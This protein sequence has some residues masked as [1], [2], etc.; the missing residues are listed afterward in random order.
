V[1]QYRDLYERSTVRDS[2][3][4]TVAFGEKAERTPSV[5]FVSSDGGDGFG[6]ET[7]NG[8]KICI[9]GSQSRILARNSGIS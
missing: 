8:S 9:T 7:L 6:V 1:W 4:R 5:R 2:L 3:E